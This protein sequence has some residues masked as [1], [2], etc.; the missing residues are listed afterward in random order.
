M[1]NIFLGFIWMTNKQAPRLVVKIVCKSKYLALSGTLKTTRSMCRLK[2]IRVALSVKCSYARLSIIDIE[3]LYFSMTLILNRIPS[4]TIKALFY[5]CLLV[6]VVCIWKKN[7][8][9]WCMHQHATKKIDGHDSTDLQSGSCK[10]CDYFHRS[11][12]QNKL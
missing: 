10:K 4:N 3:V 2:T 9:A 5:K 1:C 6:T 8:H 12:L 7:N 11:S